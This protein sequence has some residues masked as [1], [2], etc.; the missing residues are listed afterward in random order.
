MGVAWC[1]KV[2]LKSRVRANRAAKRHRQMHRRCLE[3]QQGY[4]IRGYRCPTDAAHWHIGHHWPGP[5]ET[6]PQR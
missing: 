1:A 3:C 4:D 6:R 2:S 5:F